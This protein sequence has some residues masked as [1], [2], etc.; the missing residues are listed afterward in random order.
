MITKIKCWPVF[1]QDPVTINKLLFPVAKCFF[2]YFI[3]FFFF[4]FFFVGQF[5]SFI[6]LKFPGTYRAL[7][8]FIGSL[9]LL[10]F[11][12]TMRVQLYD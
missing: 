11:K 5:G 2:F 9:V 10:T 8:P 6:P 12:G 4:F 3:Y 1:K 7:P